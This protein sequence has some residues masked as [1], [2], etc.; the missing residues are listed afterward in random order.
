MGGPTSEQSGQGKPGKRTVPCKH[1]LLN[2]SVGNI[3][4]AFLPPSRN[5]LATS[6]RLH[7]SKETVLAFTFT[8]GWLVLCSSRAES[9]L[10]RSRLEEGW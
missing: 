8:L 5:N 6:G 10:L 7:P 9:C 2:V 1:T 3:F 4:A